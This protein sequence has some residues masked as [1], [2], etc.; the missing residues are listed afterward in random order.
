MDNGVCNE[1]ILNMS[2]LV[3][4]LQNSNFLTGT[5]FK[6]GFAAIGIGN[7]AEKNSKNESWKLFFNKLRSIRDMDLEIEKL[8]IRRDKL[9]AEISP[10]EIEMIETRGSN[11]DQY[12][13]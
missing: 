7:N 4:S 13:T 2:Q 6:G 5:S 3:V 1:D 10:L 12:T 11:I 8:I 9:R